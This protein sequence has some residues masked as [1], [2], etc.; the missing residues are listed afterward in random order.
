MQDQLGLHQRLGRLRRGRLGRVDVAPGFAVGL[1]DASGRCFM[2]VDRF[3]IRSLCWRV[4]DGRLHC[5]ERA[6]DLAALPPRAAIDPQAIY[7]YLY[8]HVIPSPRTIFQGV[9]RL[10]PAHCAWFEDGKLTVAPYWVPRFEEPG[11]P[12]SPPWRP[13]SAS[14]CR[15]RWP[16][17][18]TAA[19]PPAS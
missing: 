17:N 8:F 18:W 12:A 7:D 3:A 5:A 2:A 4:I 19:S 10:P 14:W 6:D 9:Q 13:N 15:T 16:R 11:K 1:S